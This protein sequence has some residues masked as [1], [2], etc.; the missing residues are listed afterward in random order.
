MSGGRWDYGQHQMESFLLDVSR[1]PDV[2]KRFPNLAS[3]LGDLASALGKIAHDLD[4]DLSED[5]SIEDDAKFE[6]SSL[7]ALSGSSER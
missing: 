3:R 4:W 5:S 6:K 7:Q 1:D 2:R